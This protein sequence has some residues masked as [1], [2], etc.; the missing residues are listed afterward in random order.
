MCNVS[1]CSVFSV[2]CVLDVVNIGGHKAAISPD[3]M[4]SISLPHISLL[5][6]IVRTVSVS[7]LLSWKQT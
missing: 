1:M 2:Q 3:G 4:I 6:T 7:L 5:E